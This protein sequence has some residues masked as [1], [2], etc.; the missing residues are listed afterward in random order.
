MTAGRHDLFSEQAHGAQRLRS[1]EGA[2]AKGAN[3]VVRAGKLQVFLDPFLDCIRGPD[4]VQPGSDLKVEMAM[5]TPPVH[6]Q[7]G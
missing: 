5:F 2:E 7:S 4:D 3:E 1:A 6:R